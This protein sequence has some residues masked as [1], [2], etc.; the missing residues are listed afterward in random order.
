MAPSGALPVQG[1]VSSL[2]VVQINLNKCLHA[3]DELLRLAPVNGWDVILIQEPYLTSKG[4]T[5]LPGL[6]VVSAGKTPR[7]AIALNNSRLSLFPHPE[8]SDEHISVATIGSATDSFVFVSAYHRG[9]PKHNLPSNT[10]DIQKLS[11]IISAFPNKKICF[12]MDANAYASDWGS[13]AEDNRGR[14]LA[15]FLAFEGLIILNDGAVPTYCH[16]TTFAQSFID[17]TAVSPSLSPVVENWCVSQ[18]LSF[19]DHRYICFEIRLS[20]APANMRTHS[21]RYN[22]K[23][24]DWDCFRHQLEA[25]KPVFRQLLDNARSSADIEA[26]SASYMEVIAAATARAIPLSRQ[27][28][29]AKGWWDPSLTP[30][31]REVRRLRN[32]LKGR[33]NDYAQRHAAYKAAYHEYRHAQRKSRLEAFKR[34]CTVDSSDPW[35]SMYKMLKTKSQAYAP[36]KPL[37]R[38]DGTLTGSESETIDLLFDKYFP[39]DDPASDSVSEAEVR[40]SASE[41]PETSD[42]PPFS[43]SEVK[44]S[45]WRMKARK[46]PGFDLITAPIL[47]QIIEVLLPEITLWFNKCL[48]LGCF[49]SPFK[50]AVIKF[51]PKPNHLLIQTEKAYRPLCLLTTVGKSLDSLLIKR[52]EW[53]LKTSGELSAN[54]FGFTPQTSTVDAILG[55]T[56]LT[57]TYRKRGWCVLLLAID[58]D[59]AFDSAKWHYILSALRKRNCPANLYR[60]ALDYFRDRFVTAETESC[61]VTRQATQGCMQG[62]P[63]GPLFWNILIDDLNRLPFDEH[64]YLREFADDL[65]FLVSGANVRTAVRRANNAIQTVCEWGESVSLKFNASKTQILCV[66]RGSEVPAASRPPVLMNG[67]PITF[68]ETIKYLGVTIDHQLNWTAH[69]TD[70]CAR[71]TAALSRFT[72]YARHDW[73]IGPKALKIIWMHALE[74]AV[75][76]ACPVWGAGAL[77]S[78]NAARLRTLQRSALLRVCRAYCTVSHEALYVLSGVA[79]ILL[80]IQELVANYY[81]SRRTLPLAY[82]YWPS[83]LS[84]VNISSL[85]PR[86]PYFSL[87]HPSIREC[88]RLPPDTSVLTAKTAINTALVREWQNMWTNHE[89]GR[90]THA[91]I[92]DVASRLSSK[93]M[94]SHIVSQYL[95]GHGDL[96]EYLAFYRRRTHGLCFECS[97]PDTTEH[98]LICC[99]LYTVCRDLFCA[100]VGVQPISLQCFAPF[101]LDAEKFSDFRTFCEAIARAAE[102]AGVCDP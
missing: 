57:E 49:P 35:G 79:P 40:S 37:L 14:A 87:P 76:Y 44:A 22:V 10:A 30:L 12:G 64:V 78:H 45:V 29:G 91:F 88:W 6:R 71:T 63:S 48:A 66:G 43:E 95:T 102:V 97:V 19:S 59:T 36:L 1:S 11:S 92:P 47:R 2:R 96:R 82:H 60:L 31:R 46:C 73:G 7:A 74:S 27:H 83:L 3:N 84:S 21:R 39:L 54:Q 23:R 52:I 86:V 81:V 51:I 17:V 50:R 32:R 53:S 56:D 80:R 68:S 41:L 16:Q 24:A 13:T 69:I 77:V 4:I 58:I 90:R 55:V 100:S 18:Q 70:V 9:K 65:F 15:D 28:D 62:S 75:L 67:Q 8:L 72:H 33:P 98:R 61:S 85:T 101:I 89:N 93:F 5:G 42:D 94:P 99:S 25:F 38:S 34:F 26:L 20:R